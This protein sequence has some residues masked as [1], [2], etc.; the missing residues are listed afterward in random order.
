MS[1]DDRRPDL[2]WHSSAPWDHSAYGQQTDQVVEDL[3]AHGVA[4]DLS[5]LLPTG[6]PLHLGH[7]RVFPSGD[8][9]MADLQ[10]NARVAFGRDGRRRVIT[11]TDVI[12]LEDG[13]RDGLDL[14]CWLPLSY[15]PLPPSFDRWLSAGPIRVL[16]MTRWA[17]R[18][19]EAAGHPSTYLPHGVD[20]TVFRPPSDDERAG[21]RAHFGV[22][23]DAFVVGVVAVNNEWQASRKNLPEIIEAFAALRH[24]RTDSVLLLHTDP[25]E[26]M[27]GIA[28]GPL[29]DAHALPDGSVVTTH[30]TRY[31][32]GLTRPEMAQLY[33]AIDVLAAPSAGE[34]FGVPT[35]EAQACGRP[36]VVS[37]FTAQ[38]E[39]V[40]SGWVVGGQRRWAPWARSWQFT[41]A[42]SEIT[43][44]LVEAH[45]QGRS[46]RSDAL[47]LAARYDRR[48]VFERR[49]QPFIGA[50]LA[51]G[52][53]RPD[54]S[55]A[56]E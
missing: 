2:L 8:L 51:E 26:A 33:W 30:P 36:V 31:R 48:R 9:S 56:Q 18:A 38:P 23:E 28:L 24:R 42:V 55:A 6:G 12:R 5:V 13:A 21:A 49:W 14:A 27:G 34:G 54:H 17:Q 41:P 16:A 32:L 40:G 3:A 53:T 35:I 47:A 25:T 52:D 7:R 37:D 46:V 43:A 19:L 4:V 1:D 22:A 50:W 45:D 29:L 11:L 39:L 44:A 20:T 15:D 10:S